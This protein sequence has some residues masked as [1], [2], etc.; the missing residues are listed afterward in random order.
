[1]E[2]RVFRRRQLEVEGRGAAGD[3]AA[4]ETLVSAV[5]SLSMHRAAEWRDSSY[6]RR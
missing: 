1:M 5:R 6:H 2:S 4:G 3:A